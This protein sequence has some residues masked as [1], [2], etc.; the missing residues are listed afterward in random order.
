MTRPYSTHDFFR[1][2]PNVL[3]ARYFKA[4]G[5]LRDFEFAASK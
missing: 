4:H 5:V 1:N 3:L 2:T